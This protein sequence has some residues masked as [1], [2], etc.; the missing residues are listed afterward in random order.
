MWAEK[1][2]TRSRTSHSEKE[3]IDRLISRRRRSTAA[4]RTFPYISPPVSS[5]IPP[6]S[7]TVQRAGGAY[8]TGTHAY[9]L[10]PDGQ[11]TPTRS[12]GARIQ[13]NTRGR[14]DRECCSLGCVPTELEFDFFAPTSPLP[15]VA[16]G[17]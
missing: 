14:V 13:L 4:F 12:F 11:R 6:P 15:L 17:V 3:E 5:L 16:G 1:R 2:A 7:A 8:S 9:L 10:Q